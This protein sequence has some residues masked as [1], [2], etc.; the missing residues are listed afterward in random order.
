MR[1]FI[2]SLLLCL[3]LPAFAQDFESS[4]DGSE[5]DFIKKVFQKIQPISFE[6]NREMCGYV[7][8]DENGHLLISRINTGEEASCTLPG[9][10]SKFDVVASFHTHSTYNPQYSSELPSSTDMESDEASGIDG[11]IATP[12]GR[13]WYID[14]TEM[15]AHQVCGLGCVPQDPNF[16]EDSRDSVREEYSYRAI[17][18]HESY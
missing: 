6:Q 7:G 11:W 18:K 15:T 5:L 14:S 3:S 8:Y 13:L 10:P 9:W 17:L 1:H 4:P 12:G 2:T 16:R